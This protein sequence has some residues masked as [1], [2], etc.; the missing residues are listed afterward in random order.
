MNVI[1]CDLGGTH[2]RFALFALDSRPGPG[3][4]HRLIDSAT[5]N[6]ADYPGFDQA[7]EHFLDDTAE[8]PVAACIAAAGPVVT[9]NPGTEPRQTIRLTNLPWQLDSLEIGRHFGF[10]H[11]LLLN[12]FAALVFAVS[13]ECELARRS[14]QAPSQQAVQHGQR[15]PPFLVLGPG[16]GLGA[17][18]G[19]HSAGSILALNTEAGHS[20]FSPA[21]RR[22]IA[23]LD[24]LLAQQYEPSW[25]RLVSGPGLSLLYDFTLAQLDGIPGDTPRKADARAII[26]QGIKLPDS[27]ARQTLCLFMRLLG[28]FTRNLALSCLPAAGIHLAGGLVPRIL[29]HLGNTDFLAGFHLFPTHRALLETIPISLVV[30]EHAGVL[31]ALTFIKHKLG[32]KDPDRGRACDDRG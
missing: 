6:C 12:D 10:R 24:Y 8:P 19:V 2:V 23:L 28:M 27:V 21:D 29:P 20:L 18:I 25:E 17:A 22:Q 31:G 14:V 30:D 4:T 5:L 1:A 13:G 7:L 16:T 26:E 32:G 9:Q 11:T 15:T 3:S